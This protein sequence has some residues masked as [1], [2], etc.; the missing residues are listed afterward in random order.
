MAE[1]LLQSPL[2]LTPV[3]PIGELDGDEMEIPPGALVVLVGPQGCGKSTFARRRFRET[4]IVSSDECRRL[5]ADDASNQAVSR[6]AF[7][8]FYTLLRA[9]LTHGRTT[10]ADATSLTPWSRQKLRQI[11]VARGRPMI[12]IA[13]DVPLETCLARQGR[14]ER[15]VPPDVVQRSHEAFRQALAD[16]PHE[17]YD[18]I[19]VVQPDPEPAP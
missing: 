1:T 16:L 14:R 8:V 18:R 19:Y 17:G 3:E 2:P 11:A 10:V 9:R 13:F 6:E 5:V 7:T 4:E 12:A 15:Q